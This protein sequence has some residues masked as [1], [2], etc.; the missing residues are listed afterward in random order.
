MAEQGVTIDLLTYGTGED[1]EIPGVRTVRIP[2]LPFTGSVPLGPSWRKA[3][4]DVP[5]ALWTIG[6]LLRHRYDVVHAHEEAVFWCQALKP[7]FGF[8]LIYDM[9]SSLP[10][11]LQ[12]FRYTSSPLLLGIFGALERRALASSN[13]VVTI[14]RE[15]RD[16]VR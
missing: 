13:V 6:L 9:H 2:Q 15:L 12:N 11:Q 10:Q 16:H 8:R 4:L 7:L 14:C 3:V 5:M 1:V